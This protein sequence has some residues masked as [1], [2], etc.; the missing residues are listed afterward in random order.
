MKKT[1]KMKGAE[2]IGVKVKVSK[3]LEKFSGKVLFPEKLEKANKI[4]GKLK[5]G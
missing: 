1:K 5:M 2:A 4:I 3:S